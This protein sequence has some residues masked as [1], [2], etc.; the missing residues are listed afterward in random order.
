MSNN[1]SASNDE[2]ARIRRVL[3]LTMSFFFGIILLNREPVVFA[4]EPG[5]GPA[6]LGLD[7]TSRFTGLCVQI[8]GS[9]ELTRQMAGNSQLL[10]HRLDV[11]LDWAIRAQGFRAKHRNGATLLTEHWT[12]NTLPHANNLVNVVIASK[13]T[14]IPRSEILRVLCPGGMA[15]FEGDAGYT[16]MAKP[17][18][19]GLDA[20]THQWHG[21]DGGLV[22]EDTHVGVPQGL[23]WVTGPLFAM[24]GRKSST[25]SLVSA[26]G[27]NFYVTQNVV[28]NVGR[29]KMRQFLVARDAFNGLLLW[30]R[31]WT[32]PFVTGNG[33][34]NP[35]L[36]AS[37]EYVYIV[38]D[39]HVLALNA[40][41]GKTRFRWAAAEDPAKLLHV[42]STILVQ[43]AGGITALDDRLEKV[44]WSFRG[45]AT[46][47]TAS[48]GDQVFCL[49]SGRSKDGNFKHELVGISLSAGKIAWRVNT[50]PQT[51]ARR[52]RINFA[53][54]GFVALQAHGS[55]HL[56]SAK[57]GDHLWT[58]KTDAMPGKSYVDERYVGHFLRHGLVWMLQHNS[59]RKSSGQN[60]WVGLDPLTGK[61]RRVLQTSGNW[62]KTATPAKMGCQ[63][64]IASDRFIMI[65]RQ[66]TFIDFETGQKRPFKFTRGGCGLGFVPA[67]GLVY[68]HP[69]ACG[70][71]SEVVRG[72]MGMHS[73]RA[74]RFESAEA[75]RVERGVAFQEVKGPPT[76]PEDWPAYRY[77]GR[78]GASSPTQ[79]DDSLALLWS[80]PIV[81]H[82]ET[83]STRAWTLR[84]GNRMTA[85]TIYDRSVFVADVDSGQ[86]HALDAVS[87][88]PRW[89]F[90]AAGRIDSPPTLHN[91][92][93]LF[94]SHNGYVYCVRATDGRLVWRFRAAPMD[95]RIVAFGNVESRWPV[96]GTVLVQDDT[97]FVAAGRAPDADGGIQVHALDLQSGNPLWSAQLNNPESAG[98]CD[99]LVAGE[100]DVFL[101]NWRFD[102]QTGEHARA[103]SN[104][105]LRGGKVGLLE[106]SWL[107]HNLALRKNIQTWTAQ[108]AA[109]QL[110]AFSRNEM[111]GYEAQSRTLTFKGQ[112]TWSHSVPKPAQVTSLILT[113]SHVVAA[114]SRDRQAQLAPGILWLLGR[115]DGK[116]TKTIELPAEAVFD[117][118]A[119]SRNQ[120]FV[121]SQNGR[122]YCFGS[123]TR[124]STISP[125]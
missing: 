58:R 65:P 81:P 114:G 15:F 38:D 120:V 112:S 100:E 34:T 50:Q 97:A 115:Q 8:G 90:S 102:P 64:L 87:G 56:Y 27:R 63:L 59:E 23:Q 9:L 12:R 84:T 36:V 92:L 70:C 72:F 18:P 119:A 111:V 96:S 43:A 42:G 116:V 4:A 57:S 17:I 107:K 24:A 68:S 41:T 39:G 55:L 29:D 37:A 66:A 48:V 118:L 45:K 33:E 77:N 21:A 83:R 73:Q 61:Q 110:L 22:T 35:R 121:S 46:H 1:D 3:L 52:V 54:D 113:K 26:G 69:H 108:D 91:G 71:F 40:Q 123:K 16:R 53:R 125:E 7:D 105:H 122:L 95:H 82:R 51:T 74:V 103:S 89:T 19:K 104:S 2:T 31:Q 20:W 99:F 14:A 94:G 117:G 30:Q 32:G 13:N 11:D 80:K 62:P 76:V 88:Q 86:L 93:C 101:S 6:P 106:A 60:Q 28:K 75:K 78:R 49:V 47:G 10:L 98:L 124:A 67:N 44:I 109:G 79:L 5:A 25:Q 85:P